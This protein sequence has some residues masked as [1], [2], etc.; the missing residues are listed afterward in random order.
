MLLRKSDH[1][2]ENYLNLYE[3][4]GNGLLSSS[5]AANDEL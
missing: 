2:L 4:K 5:L 3:G 1:K